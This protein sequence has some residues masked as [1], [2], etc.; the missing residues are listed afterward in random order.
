MFPKS[1]YSYFALSVGN[2]VPWEFKDELN[3]APIQ[4]DEQ[5]EDHEHHEGDHDHHEGDHEH[6]DE[7]HH[8]HDEDHHHHDHPTQPKV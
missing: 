8:H 5:K 3:D 1:N 2:V 6:H 4:V 7:D